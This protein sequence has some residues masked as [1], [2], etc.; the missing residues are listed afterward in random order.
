MSR[1]APIGRFVIVLL[2]VL[3]GGFVAGN[4]AEGPAPVQLVNGAWIKEWLVLGPVVSRESTPESAPKA[5]AEQAV[6][7]REGGSTPELGDPAL[8]W[9]RYVAPEDFVTFLK[10]VGSSDGSTAY[11]YCELESDLAGEAVFQ[12]R[13]LDVASV[14]V[15]GTAVS[16]GRSG[17]AIPELS[18][19][20]V[21]LQRGRNP[22]LIKVSH[23]LGSWE[24]A[25][26]VLPVNRAVIRGKLTDPGGAGVKDAAVQLFQ[27]ND[28]VLAAKT[29]SA[30]NYRFDIFP[31]GGTY[32]LR[33]T[34]ATLGVW[35][36]GLAVRESELQ[37]V[38]LKLEEAV[39]IS[40]TVLTLDGRTPQT[41]VPVQ[42]LS[43]STDG[44]TERVVATVLSDERGEYKFVG[45][46]PG[47]Y[48]VRCHSRGEYLYHTSATG[49]AAKSGAAELVVGEGSLRGIHLR[50]PQIKNGFW[51]TYSTYDG[52]P[53]QNV[54][55]LQRMAD[56]IMYVGFSG[57]GLSEFDGREFKQ[58]QGLGIGGN[59]VTSLARAPDGSLWI[60]SGGEGVIRYDGV[61]SNRFTVAE[62]LA[63]DGVRT[64]CMTR[65]GMLWIGT[66]SGLS[67]YDGH[68]FVNYRVENGLPGNWIFDLC[69]GRDGSIW[70]GTSGGA[71]RFDGERFVNVDFNSG[72]RERDVFSVCQTQDGAM[73][74]G[75]A[76]GAVRYQGG[77]FQRLTARHGLPNDKV[78]DLLEANDG[79]LWLATD[80]GI[81]SYRETVLVNYT[82]LDGLPNENVHQ[83][84]AGADGSLWLATGDGLSR[85]DPEGMVQW[86]HKD[87]LGHPDGKFN[88]I[89]SVQEI[90]SNGVW[91]AT[92]DGMY[93]CDGAR[94]S[95]IEAFDPMNGVSDVHRAADGTIWATGD[96]LWEYDGQT[97]DKV[98]DVPGARRL[99]SDARGNIWFG[100]LGGA[101][102]YRPDTR[103]Q[104]RFTVSDGLLDND[105]WGVR[106]GL[107]DTMW[108]GTYDGLCLFDG[109]RLTDVRPGQSKKERQAVW[110]IRL[111][112]AGTVWLGGSVVFAQYA[113]RK[114]TW[115][116]DTLGLAGPR[117]WDIAHTADGVVWLA[118]E[119]HGLIGFDHRFGTSVATVLD[120]RD[121]LAGKNARVVTVDSRGQLWIATRDGGLTR[122]RRGTNPPEIRLVSVEFNDN[123]YTNFPV[124]LTIP[125]GHRL[126]TTC[127]EIDFKTHPQKR[128]F[129]YRVTTADGG[130]ITNQVAKERRFDFIAAKPGA[131]VVEI[132]AI[133]R[134]LN[135]SAA[136]RV[137]FQ[138]VPQWYRN[139][140]IAVP[141]GSMSLG[142]L[143]WAFVARSL[144]FA[145]RREAQR[146]QGQML[147]QERLARESL[148]ES[149][150]RL[151]E[152]R[153][154]AEAAKGAAEHARE[155]AEVAN[156]SKSLF[157]ANMSHEIRT[158]LNAILG[159]SQIL[160]RDPTLPPTHRNALGTI[161]RS[162]NHLLNLINEIL[163]L[164]KIESGR[165][166]VVL[167]DFDLVEIVSDLAAMF[168]LRCQQNGLGWRV[169]G[170]DSPSL[171]VRG[172]E[173]KLRQ[174][175]INLLA[176]AVKFTDSGEVT[177]R[178]RRQPDHC[179]QF[180]VQ[181]TGPGIL[182]EL[183][184]RIFEPFTQGAEGHDRGGTGLGLAISRR[185]IEL[186]GG[187]LTLESQLGVGSRFGFTL[188]LPPGAAF[189]AAE[190]KRAARQA[191]K[192]KA[193][194]RLRVLVLDDIVE[195]RDMLSLFLRSLGVEVTESESGQQA[196]E[197]LRRHRHDLAFLDIQMPG[198]TGIEVAQLVLAEH[199]EACPKLVAISASVLAHEQERYARIGFHEF[200]PKPFR[201]EQICECLSRLLGAG[202]EYDDENAKPAPRETRTDAVAAVL[203]RE[204]LERLRHAAEMYSVTEF[205]G[206]LAEVEVVEPGGAALA[207]RLRELSRN[208]QF[209]DILTTLSHV[210]SKP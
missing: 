69:E 150:R 186:M 127:R 78:N 94:I 47:R 50:V 96:G 141:I 102:R 29:D 142:L 171:M 202:F 157:L 77:V 210:Q 128:Q 37:I 198:M 190:P 112:G 62:G 71:A 146:L 164:A 7:P 205:E 14:W 111:D 31:G 93:R 113:G 92:A 189:R 12:L 114:F 109:E 183:R 11:A 161:E 134:D 185:Q 176:N 61:S 165:M 51:Q 126:T 6:R 83:I 19:A 79:H 145:K 204:L 86:N 44:S 32:D 9:K 39:S 194:C 149:N 98:V 133:D 188:T 110:S 143:V 203:P 26:R 155:A 167:V 178:I 144:Y 119:N 158:P 22:C 15:N 1:L 206:Y 60:G 5:M 4:A 117:V 68:K 38:D 8:V 55:C 63:H 91:V 148:Q 182:P 70:I 58:V 129:L 166:E 89:S 66:R 124:A 107:G 43:L 20:A 130:T 35:R 120:P 53:H 159:Y 21:P 163:D 174:V 170:L 207:E 105:V 181:D 200:I 75:T 34:E 42:A 64:L 90:S 108:L 173:G 184:E 118:T 100:T 30:G 87:G 56:G 193:G 156:H 76:H 2:W 199:G 23:G 139:A 152:A 162:G 192:L 135:Y 46:K 140:W 208:V 115:L 195:N 122:Y 99:D 123:R 24:F 97:L 45:L 131:Y 67:K 65:D 116:D 180:E 168:K 187:S 137:P 101:W 41:T 28:E 138:V 209:D 74:F 179:F 57:G 25:L 177:L 175:L 59:F 16:F 40:G 36:A 80:G 82:R 132:R 95:R 104:R 33:T 136:V 10:A 85:F 27:G 201:F 153:A 125:T 88:N 106:R 49:N 103:E 169:A 17:A 160:Q 18:W 52:L 196:L 72:F 54:A 81:T 3:N 84:H 121:G 154:S 48:R 73:W 191:R 13:A 151:E 197:E 172:D 147:H